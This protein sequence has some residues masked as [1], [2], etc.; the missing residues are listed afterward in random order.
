VSCFGGPLYLEEAIQ[1]V[2]LVGGFAQV[3]QKLEQLLQRQL[4]LAG[5]RALA[6]AVARREGRR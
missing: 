2:L 1:F 5:E 3:Q 4:A 6:D